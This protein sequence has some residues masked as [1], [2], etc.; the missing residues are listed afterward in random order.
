MSSRP[1]SSTSKDMPSASA[2]GPGL[3]RSF[4]LPSRLAN[5]TRDH[6]QVEIGS[7]DGIE[8][9]FVH[10]SAKIVSFSTA[11]SLRSRPS[12]RSSIA[13]YDGEG[14]STSLEWTSPTERTMALGPLEIYRV[15]G[16]V[17]FL[18]SGSLLHAILPRSQCWCV[19]GV[20]KFA[21]R[22]PGSTQEDLE[23]VEVLKKTL[24]KVLYY[25]RTA[26]PFQRGFG[27]DLPE[28]P[29]RNSRRLS[30]E[31]IEPA[32]RWKL[33]KVWR[34]EGADLEEPQLLQPNR[35]ASTSGEESGK[36]QDTRPA[37]RDKPTQLSGPF[38]SKKLAAMRSVTAPPQLSL[39]SSPP[40]K[41]N[42]VRKMAGIFDQTARDTAPSLTHPLSSALVPR[43]PPTP[44]SD[45]DHDLPLSSPDYHIHEDIT[46]EESVNSATV[47]PIAVVADE[48]GHPRFSEPLIISDTLSQSDPDAQEEAD[49]TI[50]GT[51]PPDEPLEQAVA[52]ATEKLEEELDN[53][54]PPITKASQPPL[55]NPTE[56]PSTAPPSTS[57]TETTS[58]VTFTASSPA[59]S[60]TSLSTAASWSTLPV[61]TP[62][63]ATDLLRQRR[64]APSQSPSPSTRTSSSPPPASVSVSTPA[65]PTSSTTALT[66]TSPALLVRKTCALFLGPPANLVATMLRIAAR[67]VAS[68][69]LNLAEPAFHDLF[70]V[71]GGGGAANAAATAAAGRLRGHRRVPGSWDLSDDDE[72]WGF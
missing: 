2:L 53:S 36:E 28:M 66:K 70:A 11:S 33:N 25:E 1:S 43:L 47:R 48:D 37:S 40:S 6:Q 34:P 17:A 51:L 57:T 15:P 30:R 16:S 50:T 64:R 69:A 71:A 8:T 22:L 60:T 10:P 35:S 31:L 38:P 20:S 14:E 18:H 61:L 41:V 56:Q 62:S 32:K 54:T 52:G 68:G 72:D 46:S 4:T 45:D 63:E 13:S 27:H 3:R 49:D 42:K 65:K 24:A 21:M 12:S 59:L 58:Y 5:P 67:L 29:S 44:E 19:D 7:A 23:H 26:C 39:E 9:L 55:S